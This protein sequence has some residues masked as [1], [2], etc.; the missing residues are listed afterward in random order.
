MLEVPELKDVIKGELATSGDWIL[1]SVDTRM[2]WPVKA[3]KIRYRGVELWI[4]PVTKDHFPGVA[5]NRAHGISFE[6]DR[7]KQDTGPSN[8][9]R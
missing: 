2:S 5:L 4:L 9:H 1:A 6:D 7:R 8:W 3:Q